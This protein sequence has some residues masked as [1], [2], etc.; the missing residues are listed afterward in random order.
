MR[1]GKRMVRCVLQSRG[2][3]IEGLYSSSMSGSLRG[4]TLRAELKTLL[5][6][7]ETSVQLALTLFFIK[8]PGI[9]DIHLL[10]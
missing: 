1:E 9:Y 3:N 6:Y 8:N 2:K 4:V 5:H 7:S 10:L